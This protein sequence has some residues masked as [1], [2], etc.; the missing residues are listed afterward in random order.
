MNIMLT[1]KFDNIFDW[2]IHR[3]TFTVVDQR[4]SSSGNVEN[5][6]YPRK[7]YREIS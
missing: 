3:D 7:D 5:F 4:P 6:R 2:E 1:R